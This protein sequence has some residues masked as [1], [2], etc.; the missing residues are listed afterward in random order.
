MYANRSDFNWNNNQQRHLVAFLLSA[1]LILLL[2]L[3]PIKMNFDTRLQPVSLEVE[4]V[5]KIAQKPV[6]NEP[7]TTVKTNLKPKSETK[8][9][10]IPKPKI[11]K[12]KIIKVTPIKQK[13]KKNTTTQSAPLPSSSVILNTYRNRKDYKEIDQ[14]FKV[15][16][17]HEQDFKFKSIKPS[18]I[19]QVTKYLNEEVDKPQVYMNFYSEGVAGATERFFDKISYQK[20]FTTKYGT[21]IYCGGVEP[22]VMCSWK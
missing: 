8:P 6:K 13:S 15:P 5:Q 11:I 19:Y 9:L 3:I 18:K 22:L 14:E 4:L 20:T 17:G 16:T 1:V 7:I 21:K 12:S 2:L 10:F